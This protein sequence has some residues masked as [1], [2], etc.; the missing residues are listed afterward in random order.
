MSCMR[1]KTS[2]SVVTWLSNSYLMILRETRK[3]W[4]T[5]QL[6]YERAITETSTDSAPW[7]IVPSDRKWVRDVAVERLLLDTFRRLDPQF[8]PPDP[9][10]DGVSLE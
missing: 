8:P 4:N 2:S 3:H 10:L 5:Y 1:L 9:R 7:W 6:A